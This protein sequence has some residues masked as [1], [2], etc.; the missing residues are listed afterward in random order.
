M[1][2]QDKINAFD[3]SGVGIKNGHFIGL[4]FSEEEASIVLVTVPWDVTVSF[5]DGTSTGPQNILECSSQL[6]L[7]D[8]DIPDAW[9]MGI[10]MR[11]LDLLWLNRNNELRPL[12]ESYIEFLESGGN[13]DTDLHF[14]GVLQKLNAACGQLKNWVFEETTKLLEAGKAVGIVGG[15]HSVPLGFLEALSNKYGSFGILQID[16]HQDLR[17]AYEG[18]TYSHASIFYNAM[19]FE[20]IGPLVQVGIRDSCEEECIF[21][22]NNKDKLTVWTDQQLKEAAFRGDNFY[23]ICQR[24]VAPLPELVYI[25]FDIDGLTPDLCPHTG[26]PVPGGLTFAEAFF[27]IKLLVESGRKIIGFDLCEVAGLEHDWDGNVG[28]RVL[29]RL[30]NWMGKS[31]NLNHSV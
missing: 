15:E 21:V 20:N 17:K 31:Q 28:A 2:K 24:I 27:L 3:P 25:S 22:E 18:F 26:T 23:E 9:K 7:F 16:A 8:P 1:T 5:A 12:S 13:P 6:D 10:F 19:Q 29:Y 11:H 4:P 30:C 14:K